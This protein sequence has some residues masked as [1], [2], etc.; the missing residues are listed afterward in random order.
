THPD[1]ARKSRSTI[2]GAS[3]VR[4][5]GLPRVHRQATTFV[6]CRESVLN[7]QHWI[8][9]TQSCSREHAERRSLPSPVPNS[10]NQQAWA[11][12][13]EVVIVRNTVLFLS[14]TGSEAYRREKSSK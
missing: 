10:D 6:H 7:D 8:F 13:L 9:T 14:P 1:T 2:H 5:N 12:V 3:V 11:R 4:L